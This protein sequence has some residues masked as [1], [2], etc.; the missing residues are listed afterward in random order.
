MAN[1]YDVRVQTR[2]EISAGL[3]TF[4]SGLAEYYGGGYLRLG[5]P[6]EI[7]SV[8]GPALTELEDKLREAGLSHS[9]A[10]SDHFIDGAGI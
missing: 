5:F 2:R 4:L 6:L 9:I 7:P 3:L 8:P 10:P 1:Q